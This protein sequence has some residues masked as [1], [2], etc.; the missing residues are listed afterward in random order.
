MA[1]ILIFRAPPRNEADAPTRFAESA[2]ILFFTGVRYMRMEEEAAPA[3]VAR[4]PASRR[5]AKPSAPRKPP[6]KRA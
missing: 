4:K 5:A 6:R 1:E 2:T 3:A